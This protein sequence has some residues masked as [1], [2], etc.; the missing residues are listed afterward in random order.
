MPADERGKIVQEIGSHLAE[1]S[2]V[3]PQML[4]AAIT[5]LGPPRLLART[6]VDDWRL[7]RALDRGH[8]P[9]ILLAILRRAWRSFAAVLIGTVGVVLYAFAI[10]FLLI[11]VLKPIWPANVGMWVDAS[12]RILDFG[13]MSDWPRTGREVLGWW[14]IPVSVVFAII[15]WLIAGLVMRLGGRFLLRGGRAR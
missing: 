5:Q 12:G 6:F 3:G 10:G 14:I 13:A 9:R 8:A 4:G 1:R 11:A 2:A 7:S 15:C